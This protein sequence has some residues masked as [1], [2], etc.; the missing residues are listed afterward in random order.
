MEKKKIS[1]KNVLLKSI[2]L[3]VI[4]AFLTIIISMIAGGIS[5]GTLTLIPSDGFGWTISKANYIGYNSICSFA[6]FSSLM[7]FGMAFV[8]FFLLLKVIKYRRRKT[9]QSKI[10]IEVKTSANKIR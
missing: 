4:F 9:K 1:F 3:I 2:K 5:A 7:L 6:P 10:Y 8:G